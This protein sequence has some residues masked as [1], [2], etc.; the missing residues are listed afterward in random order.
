MTAVDAFTNDIQTF[1][2]GD[3]VADFDADYHRKALE[4]AAERCAVVVTA[5]EVFS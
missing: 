4:Y 1:L 2:V 3:G 5:K